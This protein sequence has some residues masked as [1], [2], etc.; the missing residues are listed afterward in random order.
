M[1]RYWQ[2]LSSNELK[3]LNAVQTVVILPVAAIEQHGPHLPLSTD[4][5]INQGLLEATR[6]YLPVAQEVLV[7]PTQVVGDSDEHCNFHGSLSLGAE[8]CIA[9]W[10]RLG[11]AV[12][13][14]GFR[15]LLIFNTHGG[16]TGAVGI[17]AQRLRGESSMLVAKLNYFDLKLPQQ[18]LPDAELRQG[19]H[20]GAFETSL[21]MALFPHKVRKDALKH[22]APVAAALSDSYTQLS[23]FRRLGFAW[24]AEDLNPSGVVGDTRL[25][26]AKIGAQYVTALAQQLAQCMIDIA[27]W[28]LDFVNISHDDTS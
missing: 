28:P 3:D 12:A 24:N 26:N 18:L 27:Q 5:D 13:S 14:A 6:E 21:M 19:I 4:A 16:Q 1:L 11:K 25:A 10:V 2:D 8:I 20:G 15:R 22:F 23:P 9:A 7:L 17:T